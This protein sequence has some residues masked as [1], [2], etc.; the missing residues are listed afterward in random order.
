M[1]GLLMAGL[2]A[3][4]A[5][6]PAGVTEPA[7]PAADV[8]A[9]GPLY[10]L[11]HRPLKTPEGKTVALRLHGEGVQIFRCEAQESGRH[12]VYRLPEAKLSDASGQVVVRHGTNLSFEHVDTSLLLGE[13]TDH[14]PAPVDNALPWVL[15]TTRAFGKGAL[16]GVTHVQRIDTVGGMPPAGCD[17][18]QLGH[19]LRVP[20]TADF[21]FYR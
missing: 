2:L 13:I 16:T 11:F 17:A 15:M 14:V 4:C 9:P 7:R 21:I 6:T 3:A 20:F 18:S 19:L 5:Q 1:L 8:A 10:S 12:W